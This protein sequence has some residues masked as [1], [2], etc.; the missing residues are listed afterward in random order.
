MRAIDS[1]RLFVTQSRRSLN[2]SNM[3]VRILASLV[4]ALAV[5]GCS[6]YD[7]ATN[8]EDSVFGTGFFSDNKNPNHPDWNGSWDPEVS[9][10]IRDEKAFRRAW[11]QLDAIEE[12]KDF[13]VLPTGEIYPVEQPS[14]GDESLPGPTATCLSQ[15]SD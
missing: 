12:G 10:C 2:R 14:L 6:F 5:A 7:V 15:H 4:L 3:N 8:I 1:D 13:V 9:R 11:R